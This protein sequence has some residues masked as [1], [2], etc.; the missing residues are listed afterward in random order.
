MPIEIREDRFWQDGTAGRFVPARSKGG[1]IRP[2]LIVLHDTAGRLDKGSSVTWFTDPKCET[3]AHFVIERDGSIVQMIACDEKAF[4][5]GE[6]SFE[7]RRYC[8]AFS[9][10]IEIVN[11]GKL[12]GTPEAAKSW[13]GVIYK[14]STTQRLFAK[15]T[16]AHGDGVWMDYT[17]AQVAAVTELCQALAKAY[18]ITAIT[19]HWHIS[20]GR[21]VD[22]NPLFPLD[23]VRAAAFAVQ[24]DIPPKSGL[25]IDDRSPQVQVAQRALADLGY[26][27][28]TADGHFGPQMRVA[29]LAFQAENDLPTAGTLSQSDLDVLFSGK[30]KAMPVGGRSEATAADIVAAGSTIAAVGEQQATTGKTVAYGS[31]AF[32]FVVWL[33]E[34][35]DALGG[36]VKSI[37]KALGDVTTAVGTPVIITVICAGVAVYGL[38]LWK[39]GRAIVAARLA[40]HQSGAN[41]GR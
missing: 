4:H 15:K 7:G 2:T 30:A 28:G 18:P 34:K 37:G 39:G 19:T 32:A 3:S 24:P 35:F 17:A 21:K 12:T 1:R 5:A 11:P 38:N 29:V 40:D 27:V 14:P 9:I 8:N 22:P 13:F 41:V 25:S 10:G 20:P 16:A 33:G 23:I 26:Q 31:T 36:A 6:S